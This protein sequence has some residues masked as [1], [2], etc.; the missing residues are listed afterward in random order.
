MRRCLKCK[1]VLPDTAFGKNRRSKD[2]LAWYCKPCRNAMSRAWKRKHR[3][4][5]REQSGPKVSFR[6]RDPE[7]AKR[8]GLVAG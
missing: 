5:M 3:Q 7:L 1:Q 6:I 4:A 2:G 8:L